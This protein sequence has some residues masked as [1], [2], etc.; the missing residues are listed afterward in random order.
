MVSVL[1]GEVGE[2]IS[3]SVVS[4]ASSVGIIIITFRTPSKLSCML[5]ASR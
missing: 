5:L 4:R 2:S 3:L 1:G